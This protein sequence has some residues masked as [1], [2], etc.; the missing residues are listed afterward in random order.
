M[1]IYCSYRHTHTHTHTHTHAC[2]ITNLPIDVHTQTVCEFPHTHTRTRT[3]SEQAIV[4]LSWQMLSLS[5]WLSKNKGRALDALLQRCSFSLQGCP[6]LYQHIYGGLGYGW[7]LC[8]RKKRPV[9]DYMAQFQGLC[10]ISKQA[11]A[12]K[13]RTVFKHNMKTPFGLPRKLRPMGV[14]WTLCKWFSEAKHPSQG[15]K[16]VTQCLLEPFSQ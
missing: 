11:S 9:L 4:L 12:L 7:P 13:I 8:C 16:C 5:N 3:R 14:L 1:L 6:L 2:I 10:W 15:I